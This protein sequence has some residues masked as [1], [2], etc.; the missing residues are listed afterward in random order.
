[1]AAE[2]EPAELG[3]RLLNGIIWAFVAMLGS[4]I[5]VI[6]L[7]MRLGRVAKSVWGTLVWIGCVLSGALDPSS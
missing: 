5:G 3:E 7:L 4:M 2:V 1:M 6:L